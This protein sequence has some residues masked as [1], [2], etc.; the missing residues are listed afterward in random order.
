MCKF[1]FPSAD[2][3]LPRQGHGT[4]HTIYAS[5]NSSCEKMGWDGVDLVIIG[6]DFQVSLN[7]PARTLTNTFAR[8]FVTNTTS[9]SLQCQGD[10]DEWPTF[11]NTTV[12]RVQ[13]LI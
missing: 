9:M 12:A 13:L 1:L 3:D 4:L 7:L 2:P 10:F 6:G 5:I 8:Q 11:M